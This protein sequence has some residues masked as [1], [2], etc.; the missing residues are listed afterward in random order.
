MY[1]ISEY[2]KDGRLSRY[3]RELKRLIE[4]KDNA[5]II[6]LTEKVFTDCA[7][8]LKTEIH[9]DIPEVKFIPLDHAN[10]IQLCDPL[11]KHFG[12]R[13]R[14]PAV[15]I[16]KDSGNPEIYIDF[17]E[18]FNYYQSTGQAINFLIN[19][20]ASYM[21][22]LIHAFDPKKGEVEVQDYVFEAI[23][24][25]TE[26][27]VPQKVKEARLKESKKADNE[28]TGNNYES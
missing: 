26:I 6:N 25:F 15:I 14:S 23:E 21:E 20:I 5:G 1:E 11:D 7:D 22:E 8:Y 27:K 19:I 17:E 16:G 2:P 9:L 18:H 3:E 28:G 10:Y 12:K 13:K 4:Q 24:G